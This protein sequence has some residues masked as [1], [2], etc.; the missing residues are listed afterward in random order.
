[1]ALLYGRAGRL[2]AKNGGFR[3]GQA[4]QCAAGHQL[5][6]KP[7]S[8]GG[9]K[10]GLYPIVTF[11]N[12]LLNMIG[13]MVQS[14]LAVLKSDNRILPY[15][16]GWP[17]VGAARPAPALPA[18]LQPA[19]HLINSQLPQQQQ[20]RQQQQHQ[21][22]QQQLQL[23]KHQQQQRQQPSKIWRVLGR[24][25]SL[26]PA[27]GDGRARLSRELEDLLAELSLLPLEALAAEAKV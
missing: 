21:E 2:T 1:M 14:G 6:P 23:E 16:K 10:V 8:G 20:R 13:N 17:A 9:P 11:E 24:F 18:P 22:Q 7:I 25:A 15:P 3:P 19:A 26:A 4:E 12:Q 5:A 27:D